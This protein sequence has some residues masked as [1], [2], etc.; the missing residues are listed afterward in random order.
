MDKKGNIAFVFLGIFIILGLIVIGFAIALIFTNNNLLNK[1]PNT[2]LGNMELFLKSKSGDDFIAAN[3]ILNN[4]VNGIASQ[5]K[6]ESNAY[7]PINVLSNQSYNFRCWA[8]NYY[9]GSQEVKFTPNELNLNKSKRDCNMEKVG[10]IK[11]LGHKGDLSKENNKITINL[12]AEEGNIKSL[13]VCLSWTVGI[14]NA[15]SKKTKASCGE[16]DWKNTTFSNPDY[17]DCGLQT[18]RCSSVLGNSCEL[19]EIEIPKRFSQVHDECS[20]TG[21][22]LLEGESQTLSIDVSTFEIKNSLDFLSLTFF[23][24]DLRFTGSEWIQIHE[25]NGDDIGAD[26]VGY[27][28]EF[29]EE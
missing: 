15:K 17:Y 10:K 14:I 11:I 6:I 26:T 7:F 20:L 21:I 3:Y 27:T 13:G 24:N 23:D 16:G 12:T 29:S 2:N 4:E 22:Y 25:I 9:I 1:D 5:G 28:I 18:E 8:D 19:V